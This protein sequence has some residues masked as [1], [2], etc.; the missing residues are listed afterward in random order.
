[1]A[2]SERTIPANVG[3]Q[4]AGMARERLIR[5]IQNGD[6]RGELREGKWYVMV[7]DVERLRRDRTREPQ[8]AT[9]R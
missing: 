9:V 3:A 7:S 1:M 4:M 8:V 5:R 2:H 6:L